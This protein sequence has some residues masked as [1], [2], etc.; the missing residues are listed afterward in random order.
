MRASSFLYRMGGIFILLTSWGALA[1]NT[2]HAD[3]VEPAART[4]PQELVNPP[5]YC[6]PATFEGMEDTDPALENARNALQ[7]VPSTK[8]VAPEKTKTADKTLQE[9]VHGFKVGPVTLVGMPIGVST[10]SSTEAIAKACASNKKGNLR[11]DTNLERR[12]YCTFYLNSGNK[13]AEKDLVHLYVPNPNAD[14]DFIQDIVHEK[15]FTD[16]EDPNGK[17]PAETIHKLLIDYFTSPM[18]PSK[19]KTK[20]DADYADYQKEV[21]NSLADYAKIDS[22]IGTTPKLV[23]DPSS[24]DPKKK[25]PNMLWCMQHFHYV[26]MGCDSMKHRGPTVFGIL[27]VKSGCTPEQAFNIVHDVWGDNDVAEQRKLILED[28]KKRRDTAIQKGDRTQMEQLQAFFSAPKPQ[29]PH[30]VFDTRS[31]K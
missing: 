10:A 2:A 26:G 24:T 29:G 23:Q 31:A 5:P 11:S 19:E 7:G 18:P 6:T 21:K 16:A 14:I 22:L 15:A 28:A 27:L 9:R 8:T 17:V 3:D 4:F 30:G 20:R 12:N 1:Q 13:Q 25:I